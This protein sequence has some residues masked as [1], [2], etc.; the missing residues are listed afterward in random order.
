M[1][2]IV[3]QVAWHN[4]SRSDR[5]AMLCTEEERLKFERGDSFTCYKRTEAELKLMRQIAP[6][7]YELELPDEAQ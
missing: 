5:L 3:T 2:L 4:K 6:R 7:V 1:K